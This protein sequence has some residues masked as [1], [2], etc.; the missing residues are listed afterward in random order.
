MFF[1]VLCYIKIYRDSLNYKKGSERNGKYGNQ[2]RLYG[3]YAAVSGQV[4]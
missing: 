3:R 1:Y 2:R 4:F